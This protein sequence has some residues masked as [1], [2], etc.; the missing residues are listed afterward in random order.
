MNYC[1][2]FPMDF[3]EVVHKKLWFPRMS[4]TDPLPDSTTRPKFFLASTHIRGHP[5][6]NSAIL[7]FL[8]TLCG[9]SPKPFT[10][11]A[12]KFTTC[13]HILPRMNCKHFDNH[14]FHCLSPTVKL[15][16]GQQGGIYI[17][18]KGAQIQ[19]RLKSWLNTKMSDMIFSIFKCISCNSV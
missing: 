3:H 1:S 7:L 4:L 5:P 15:C 19:F 9:R 14:F 11:I 12:L 2:H 16:A 10:E 8:L 18:H 6:M 17:E 13:I